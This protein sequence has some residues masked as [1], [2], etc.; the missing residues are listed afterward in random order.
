MRL[1][2][3]VGDAAPSLPHRHARLLF[4]PSSLLSVVHPAPLDT[5]FTAVRVVV[6]VVC[7]SSMWQRIQLRIGWKRW[8]RKKPFHRRYIAARGRQRNCLNRLG[9]D[10][11]SWLG[12]GEVPP[13]TA[14]GAIVGAGAGEDEFPGA[15]QVSCGLPESSNVMVTCTPGESESDVLKSLCR[16][17]HGLRSFVRRYECTVQGRVGQETLQEQLNESVIRVESSAGTTTSI[18][19]TLST[20]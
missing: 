1:L 17:R 8:R 2:C 19:C 9:S 3:D 15:V 10:H 11:A 13:A 12:K 16:F 7:R 20:K 5:V 18:S 4:S 6:V 14:G